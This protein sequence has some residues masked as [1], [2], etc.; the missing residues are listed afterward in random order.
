MYPLPETGNQARDIF[1]SVTPCNMV[2]IKGRFR[3]MNYLH[4]VGVKVSQARNRQEASGKLYQKLVFIEPVAP[5]KLQP[6][7]V[8]L[9][10]VT[11]KMM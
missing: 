5:S 7:P 3:T 11:S 10:A 6:P 8:S 1:W 9:H 2:E 4:I